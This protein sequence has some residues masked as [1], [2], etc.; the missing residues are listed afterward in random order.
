M[1][2]THYINN[3]EFLAA[4][5]EY[6]ETGVITDYIGLCFLQIAKGLSTKSNFFSYQFKDDMVSFAVENCLRYIN[7][8]NPEISDKPNPFGYFTQIVYYAFLRYIQMEK[9]HLYIKF[10]TQFDKLSAQTVTGDII[11][12]DSRLYG[13]SNTAVTE[14]YMTFMR[15]YINDFERKLEEKK[16][17]NKKI[18]KVDSNLEKFMEI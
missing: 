3:K 2:T 8:F 18:K 17:H 12:S 16:K 13:Q 15:T 6:K 9:K 10:K 5:I 4:L 7:N 11:E 1:K 14:D